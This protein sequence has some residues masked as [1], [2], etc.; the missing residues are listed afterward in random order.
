MKRALII[1]GVVV[2]AIAV[3]LAIVVSMIDLNKYRPRIQSELQA[4]LDRPVTL[5]TLHL[6][7]LP[8][9]VR[10]DGFTIGEAPAFPSPNPFARANQ[11]SVSVGLFSLVSGSPTIKSVELTRPQIEIIRNQQGVWNF[12]SIGSSGNAAPSQKEQTG[13]KAGGGVSLNSLK[14]TDG[15]IALTD[16]LTRQPRSVYDHIDAELSDFAPGKPFQV[17]ASVHLPGEGKQTIALD[18]RLGPLQGVAASAVPVDGHFRLEEVTLSGLTRFA[19]GTIPPGTDTVA[20]GD[21]RITSA[22]ENL[23]VTS[24]LKLENTTVKGVK[25]DYPISIKCDLTDNRSTDVINIRTGDIKLGQTPIS[26][27][28]TYDNG[29]KPANLDL[30]AKAQNAAITEMARLAGAF[31]VAMNPAYQIKGTLNADVSARGPQNNPQLAGSVQA[32]GLEASGGEI[33]QPVSVPEINLTLSPA[34]ILSNSFAAQSGSTRLTIAFS[35]SQYTTPNPAVD[36]TVKTEGANVPEL[37]NIAKAYGATAA[38]GMS[39]SGK[40][41]LDAH[42]MGPIKDTSKLIYTG[43][44]VLSNVSLSSPAFS[45]PLNIRSANL[46]LA[47][48]GASVDNLAASLGGSDIT[49]NLSAR[50]FAAPEV[51]FALSSNKVDV[52]EL[53][54]LQ[55]SGESKTGT[56]SAS[57]TQPSLLSKTTGSGTIAAKS[58]LA[59]EIVLTNVNAT[60]KLDKGVIVLSPLTANLF[61]GSE[62]GSLTLD[63]RPSTPTVAVNS[64]LTG[65]DSNQLLSAVS[66]VKNKLHGSLAA[67]AN[68]GFA[69]ASSAALARTLNGKLN[70]NLSNGRLAGVNILNELSRVGR[71]VGATPQQGQSATELKRFSG[72]L[73]VHNGVANTNDL[74]AELNDGSL[75]AKGSLNLADQIINMHATAVLSSGISQSV[76]G[77]KVGGFLST[78]LANNKGELVLPVL[79]TG[80]LDKP[81]FA[82]DAQAI[83]EMKVKNLL[84]TTGDPS[85]LTT[86]V[87]GSVLGNKGGATGAI[88]SILGGKQPSNQAPSNAQQ[89]Q[90]QKPEDVV[91]SVLDQF[92]KKK[93]K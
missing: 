44:G 35:L 19:A 34:A 48:N 58:I 38:N 28:G 86:G 23:S 42:L 82:P 12:S 92:G 32:K 79:I 68:L 36:A 45:K 72:S 29:K 24:T 33:K 53:A 67:N 73:D 80:S 60:A 88:D 30:K 90:Q 3:V 74:I 31:G 66:S 16:Q 85:K 52:N 57:S 20:S 89:Q 14:I 15:Q 7:V 49:G 26:I 81:M 50:N 17:E 9:S 56:K 46:H 43:S 51:Q 18:A 27:S 55:P 2:A 84:P 91:N 59:Q 71:F 5:G 4:K 10:V 11:V 93:K 22:H 6:R 40:L 39:G 25:I 78:T 87:I 1:L 13:E 83:A 54:Q 8:L 77:S 76:G 75:S 37:L 41:S 62:S 63:T 47:Q 61:G 65:I 69:L 21:G 70:F 64:K